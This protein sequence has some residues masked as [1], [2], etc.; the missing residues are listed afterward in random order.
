MTTIFKAILIFKLIFKAI[1]KIIQNSTLKAIFKAIHGGVT[2]HACCA[3]VNSLGLG[4]GPTASAYFIKVALSK[5]NLKLFLKSIFFNSV[6]QFDS[7]LSHPPRKDPCL[8]FAKN[9]D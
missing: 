4:G 7:V 9:L 5:N 1:I 8:N 3:I 6:K 2:A